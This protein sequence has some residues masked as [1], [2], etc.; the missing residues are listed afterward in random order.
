MIYEKALAEY[1][2]LEE[3]INEL[4]QKL[5]EFPEGKLFITRN[6]NRYKWYQTDGHTQVYLS[7]KERGFAEQLAVKKYLS[8]QVD[9]MKQEKK[10][11]EFYLRHHN[12]SNQADKM[13]NE[14]SGY[15]E[16]LLPYFKPIS[17]ELSD[18]VNEPYNSNTKYPE[19]LV[20]KASGGKL[21]RSKSEMLIDMAL[22]MNRIPFRYECELQLG[23]S[24]IYPDFT[25]RHPKTGEVYYWEHFGMMDDMF[26]I[27]N[28]CAKIQTYASHG[29]TPSIHLI[30]TFETQKNPLSLD[31]INRIIEEYF[32]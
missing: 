9:E 30:T 8:Y 19:Q 21:V 15:Q 26:Y 7:K 3:Q 23:D 4:E 28:A 10:A 27:E 2:R 12:N 6:G 20:H 29:I 13:L 5:K 25:V 17:E 22:Y 32:G 1:N 18:W 11:I 16:L 14:L 31:K 24:F